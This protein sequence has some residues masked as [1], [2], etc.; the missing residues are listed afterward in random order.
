MRRRIPPFL[1]PPSS[2]IWSNFLNNPGHW[3]LRGL[4]YMPCAKL[5]APIA[6]WCHCVPL[7]DP[8]RP[9]HGNVPLHSKWILYKL[10]LRKFIVQNWFHMSSSHKSYIVFYAKTCV[11]HS[12]H[13][14][15]MDILDS[16]KSVVMHC[17]QIVLV[18]GKL[19]ISIKGKSIKCS[20]I[21]KHGRTRL[22]MFAHGCLMAY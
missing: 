21:Q 1:V 9:T 6:F 7:R 10:L 20:C 2:K 14:T 13:V 19:S 5:N 15:T 3:Y 16:G 22:H 12:C 4:P 17:V 11:M 18:A 8:F